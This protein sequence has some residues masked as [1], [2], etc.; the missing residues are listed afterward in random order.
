MSVSRGGSRQWIVQYR[1]ALGRTKRE[2]LG[3]AGMLSATN[4]RRAAGER[5]A[6]AKLGKDPH[7]ERQIAKARAAVTLGS[8][9]V[10]YLDASEIRLRPSS[11]GDAR[12]Y[13]REAWKPLHREPLHAVTRA[14]VADRL[15]AISKESGSYAANRARA[16]LSAV[17]AWLIGMGAAEKQPGDRHDQDGPGGE[18]APG[19]QTC[20]DQGGARGVPQR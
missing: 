13:M 8:K 7:A 10:P 14:H 17:Y 6:R 5:L 1:N 4:A 20:G 2:T 18:A 15:A 19:A 3:R 11:L 9:V 16:T 12:R